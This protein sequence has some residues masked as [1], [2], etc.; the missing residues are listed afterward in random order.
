MFGGS[1]Q[2]VII[3]WIVIAAVGAFIMHKTK[4]GNWIFAIGGDRDSARNAGIPVDRITVL[5]F[6]GS[7]TAA[8][9]VGMCHAILFNSAQV[10][11]GMN[12]IF[13][14]IVSVVVGGVLLT[15]GFGSIPGVFIGTITFAIVNKGI[16]FT[17]I[18]RN[19]SNLIIGVM[20]LV[21]VGMN[22][23][24]RKK[25]MTAVSKKKKG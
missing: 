20:L 11:G 16:D 13:N 5:L 14:I 4:F 6:V 21:A 3:W 12:D 18:D 9:F 22:E 7:A 15:G 8:S 25:A 17:A 10:S 1:H 2:V 24:F 23:T 19:W